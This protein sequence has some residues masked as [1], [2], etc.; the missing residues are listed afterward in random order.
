MVK[1]GIIKMM[2]MIMVK[3][4]EGYTTVPTVLPTTSSGEGAGPQKRA[5]LYIFAGFDHIM[6]I[7][8]IIMSREAWNSVKS[9]ISFFL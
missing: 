4:A 9:C 5:G 2:M 6:H 8:C 7:V 1:M 3:P